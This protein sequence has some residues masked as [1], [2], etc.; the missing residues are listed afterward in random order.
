MPYQGRSLTDLA[1][2][3]QRQVTVKHD[4]KAPTNLCEMSV[5]RPVVEP[6]P[7]KP[8]V[9]VVPELQFRVGDKFEG[10]L[11]DLMHDQLGSWTEIPS[12]YYDR[13]KAADPALL[14]HNVNVW[15]RKLKETRLVRTL[16]GRARA[17]LSNR[18]RTIDH[19]DVLEAAL[20]VLL[21][22]SKKLGNI[23]IVSCDVTEK[24]LYLKI[25]SNRLT[26][27]VKKGDAVQA[28]ITI[29]NSEVGKGS[30][31]IEP[32]LLRLI[33]D[34]GATIEDS[35]VRKFHIGRQSAE[36]EAAEAV[37]RDET[38][39]LDDAAF[40]AKLQD[41]VRAAFK[42]EN[43][44][45]LKG[46]TIDATTRKIKAPIQDVVEEV[47]DRWALSE[48]VKDSFLK[49]LIEGGDITQWGL[50]NALTAVANKAAN[51]EEATELE[52]IGGTLM[53]LDGNQWQQIAA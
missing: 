2:E 35:A 51:Y 21:N 20:P 14:A 27:E 32:F 41:V 49:N 47:V 45:Q 19:H 15:L 30:V 9:L 40:V 43:F 31:N 22:E 11:T 25:V 44:A 29:S 38:R 28:G 36:L 52:K 46:M 8:S 6:H 17:F 37:Y 34:N 39:K 16:D 48:R 42:D 3:I 13:M 53:L 26:Y 24:K 12:K 50:A 18:Y 4:F 5:R 33:C 10:P 1:A 23:K 7:T